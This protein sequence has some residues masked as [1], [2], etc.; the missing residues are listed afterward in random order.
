MERD[1]DSSFGSSTSGPF[2]VPQVN[3][4]DENA[5][6]M[7]SAELFGSDRVEGE[8]IESFPFVFKLNVTFTF[9]VFAEHGAAH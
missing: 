8:Q 4:M 7:E 5:V 9:P 6:H 1:R 3:F 2:W